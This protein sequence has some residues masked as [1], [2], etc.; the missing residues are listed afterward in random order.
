[1]LSPPVQTINLPL[2]RRNVLNR[3]GMIFHPK[4]TH[5]YSHACG[6]RATWNTTTKKITYTKMHNACRCEWMQQACFR[7][8][9]DT[10]THNVHA[11]NTATNI[12]QKLCMYGYVH[13]RY[14]HLNTHTSAR[15]RLCQGTYKFDRTYVCFRK[16]ISREI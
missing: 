7:M 16:R 2:V 4:I 10:Y 1:M 13:D 6:L 3:T 15:A 14:V 9:L 8:F 5:S 12:Q 11:C